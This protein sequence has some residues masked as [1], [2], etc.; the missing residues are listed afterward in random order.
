MELVLYCHKT[1]KDQWKIIEDADWSSWI[2][3]HYFFFYEE[4]PQKQT[5]EEE[6]C[7]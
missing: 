4:A 2:Y 7:V 3:S 5:L 1:D 6:H